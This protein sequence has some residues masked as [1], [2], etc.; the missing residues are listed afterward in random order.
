V[1]RY[2]TEVADPVVLVVVETPMVV[3]AREVVVALVT[4]V[5]ELVAVVDELARGVVGELVPGVG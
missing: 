3:V 2:S 4:V 5:E 1:F